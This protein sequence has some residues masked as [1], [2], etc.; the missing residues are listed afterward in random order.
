MGLELGIAFRKL[1]VEVTVWRRVSASC[2]S[3]TAS[4]PI[5]CAAGWASS[6]SRSI[7]APGR[8]AMPAAP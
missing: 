7:S 6:A 2:R 8:R 3:I 4:S 5:R 1:G